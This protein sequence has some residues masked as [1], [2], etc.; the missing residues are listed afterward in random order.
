MAIGEDCEN[1][2]LAAKKGAVQ[3][4]PEARWRNQTQRSVR[5]T[6]SPG[7]A[8][9]AISKVPVEGVHAKFRGIMPGRTRICEVLGRQG[10]PVAA[11]PDD[12]RASGRVESPN[13][14]ALIGRDPET[15]GS[16]APASSC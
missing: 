12:K 6:R 7:G 14:A 8:E 5:H 3:K 4:L 16:E 13:S 11:Q 15:P 2:H 9:H 10:I 1:Q